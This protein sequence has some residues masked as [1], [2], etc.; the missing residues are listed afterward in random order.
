MK[1]HKSDVVVIAAGAAGLAAAV[2]AAESGAS[3]TVFEKASTIGGSGNMAG[4]PFGVESRMQRSRK[5]GITCEEAFRIHMDYAHWRVDARLVKAFIDKSGDTINWL[6]KMGVEFEDVQCHNPGFSFTWHMIKGSDKDPG[7]FGF[8]FSMMKIM[9][10]KAKELGVKTLLTT[11]VQRIVKEGKGVVG[12]VAEDQSGEMIEAKAHAV[13]IATG[14]F[15]DEPKWIK[16][17]TGYEWG[18]DLLSLRIP[19]TTGDGVRMA[20]E[21]GAAPTEMIMQLTPFL[22]PELGL[23]SLANWFF[24]QPNLMINLQGERFV[25]EELFDNPTFLGNAV[26]RQKNRCVFMILDE[27]IKEHYEKNGLDFMPHVEDKSGNDFATQLKHAMDQGAENVFIS[28]SVPELAGK[29]GVDL[30]ALEKTIDEYNNASDTGRDG[31]FH[32]N[33]RYLRPVRTPKFYAARFFPSA[34]G[35]LGGIKIN[36]KTEVLTKEYEVIPGLYAAGND[37]AAIYGDSYAYLLPGNTL[38]F[39]LNSGRIAGENAAGF[40]RSTSESHCKTSL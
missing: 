13:V 30:Y 39:A 17:Y 12:V 4:G 10:D 36:C 22:V 27:A 11:P 8:G 37:A 40:A 33:A 25:N 16:K 2:A 35:S 15:G 32:K 14:G 7:Q 1:Q 21:V 3:V 24:S 31:L 19:G 23:L 5:I 34:I 6:E 20:W 26:S 38:G 9:A 18:K 29:I 28:D